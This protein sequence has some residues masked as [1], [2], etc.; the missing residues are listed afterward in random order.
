MYTAIILNNES[1]NRLIELLSAFVE[2]LPN[3]NDW[4]L[5]CHH[6]TLAFG[7]PSGSLHNLPERK[8]VVDA[9]AFNELVA[10]F[11]VRG[12]DD[13]KNAVPHVTALVNVKKRGKAVMSNDLT[14]WRAI[15]PVTLKGKV[16]VVH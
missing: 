7:T 9:F 13:S 4:E 10:A 12:A 2:G 3:S 1:Q 14:D 15:K 6:C 16:R 11:R 5:R 8:I